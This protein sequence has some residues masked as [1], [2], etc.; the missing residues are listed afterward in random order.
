MPQIIETKGKAEIVMAMAGKVVGIDP[1][2]GKVVWTCN[3]DIGWYMV[4]TPVGHDGVVFCLGGRSG[5]A[6]L[7]VRAGGRGDV[8]ASHRIWKSTKGSNVAS[9]IYHAGHLYWM[10]DS[11]GI[12]YCADAK[13]G[14]IVYDE[15][16]G[17]GSGVYAS[18]VMADGR[19]YYTE[20]SGRTLVVAAEPKFKLLA[21]NTLGKRI[22]VNASPAVSDGRLL[23]RVEQT[24]YCI[25][26]PR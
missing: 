5:V 3:S 20:R 2:S 14:E 19:I 7:A 17:G 23:M 10:H 25:S 15:R 16:I 21:Q 18:P 4:P 9:P 22:T 12:A 1:G 6:S 11:Q 26:D 8:T 13:T 24:L